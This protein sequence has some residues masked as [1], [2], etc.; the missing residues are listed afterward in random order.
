MRYFPKCYFFAF[1][2][3]PLLCPNFESKNPTLSPPDIL[4]VISIIVLVE[5]FQGPV[6]TIE[7]HL[8]QKCGI[9]WRFF[10]SRFAISQVKKYFSQYVEAKSA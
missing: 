9:F 10:Y 8:E 1:V 5:V 3:K 2:R 7:K 6:L 4:S